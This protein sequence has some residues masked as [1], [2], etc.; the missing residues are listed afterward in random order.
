MALLHNS[1]DHINNMIKLLHLL[2]KY[3]YCI[4]IIKGLSNGK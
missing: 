1:V 2:M 3:K 4:S